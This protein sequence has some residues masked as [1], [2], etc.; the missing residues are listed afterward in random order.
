MTFHDQLKSHRKR[1]GWSQAKLSEF[2]EQ[3][4]RAIWQWE[5]GQVPHILTQEG[6]MAR[7]EKFTLPPDGKN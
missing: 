4:P 3:S 7:L 6:A 1:L 5:K 2:L